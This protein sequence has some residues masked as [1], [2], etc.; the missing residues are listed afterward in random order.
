MYGVYKAPGQPFAMV[1][2]WCDNG[3]VNHYLEHMKAGPVKEMLKLK[4]L[5]DV[6]AG[7]K[8]SEHSC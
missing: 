2:A 6:F 8:Y 5:I 3:D 4:L 1:S 7:L